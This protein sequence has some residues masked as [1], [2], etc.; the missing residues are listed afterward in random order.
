MEKF[1][2]NSLKDWKKTEGDKVEKVVDYKSKK[3]RV[4]LLM[5]YDVIAIQASCILALLARFDF[6]IK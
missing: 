5:I 1:L 3:A 6:L 4:F 2:R